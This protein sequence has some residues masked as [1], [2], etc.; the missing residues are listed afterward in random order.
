MFFRLL[1][2]RIELANFLTKK[3]E[4][5][6]LLFLSAQEAMRRR[7]LPSTY[8][9]IQHLAD[10]LTQT[11][12][13]GLIFLSSLLKLTF[14]PQVIKFHS[15]YKTNDLQIM[16]MIRKYLSGLER[17]YAASDLPMAYDLTTQIFM[18][19]HQPILPPIYE[20]GKFLGRRLIKA[21]KDLQ[22][23]P[24]MLKSTFDFFRKCGQK[25]VNDDK[26]LTLALNLTEQLFLNIL[27][28]QKPVTTEEYYEICHSFGES[29]EKVGETIRKRDIF[30]LYNSLFYLMKKSY[31]WRK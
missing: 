18:F 29:L 10:K 9:V 11:E 23:Q 19:L 22:Y 1:F 31:V 20:D 3:E 21:S 14:N 26:N 4:Y 6:S 7:T 16:R 15:R 28:N 5:Q 27:Y 2:K 8:I 24:P 30:E 13:D 25:I 12:D 17:C